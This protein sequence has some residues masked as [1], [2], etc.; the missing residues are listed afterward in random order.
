MPG[1]NEKTFS[2][3]PKCREEQLLYLRQAAFTRRYSA[4]QPLG[5]MV[6]TLGKG[7]DAFAQFRFQLFLKSLIQIER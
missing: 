7:L 3:V 6:I 1:L 2:F 4:A 5:S